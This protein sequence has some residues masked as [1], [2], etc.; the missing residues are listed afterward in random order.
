MHIHTWTIDDTIELYYA[1]LQIKLIFQMYSEVRSLFVDPMV[2]L[3]LG[4]K[5]DEERASEKTSGNGGKMSELSNTIARLF[6]CT[7][8]SSSNSDGDCCCWLEFMA[9]IDNGE[10]MI[11]QK[12]E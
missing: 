1:Q 3:F 6:V 9:I 2:W 7:F 8:N 10:F 12:P 4:L 11:A 5:R